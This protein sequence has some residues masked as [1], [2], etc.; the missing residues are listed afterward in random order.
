MRKKDFVYSAL[1]AEIDAIDSQKQTPL[2]TAARAKKCQIVQFLCEKGA[3]PSLKDN[4]GRTPLHFA[5]YYGDEVS[6]GFLISHGWI[7]LHIVE[8][9]YNMTCIKVIT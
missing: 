6:A 5:A 7:V 2:H 9:I 8:L 1:G 3:N 4:E